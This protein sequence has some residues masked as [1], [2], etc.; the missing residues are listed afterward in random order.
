MFV[1][2]PECIHVSPCFRPI[3]QNKYGDYGDGVSFL[4]YGG[5]IG[6]SIV[7]VDPCLHILP[8]DALVLDA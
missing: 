2:V 7:E 6:E 3:P 4:V 1:P 5:Q 8:V